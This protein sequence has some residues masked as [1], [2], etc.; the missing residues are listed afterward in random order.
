MQILS[1][2]ILTILIATVWQVVT[3]NGEEFYG[4][5]L[6][7]TYQL[8]ALP[9]NKV[10]SLP[11]GSY[12]TFKTQNLKITSVYTNSTNSTGYYFFSSYFIYIK[13]YSLF[14]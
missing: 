3:I 5:F 13:N 8:Q 1:V 14:I 6:I 9:G 4:T 11:E 10:C 2:L 12:L 7:N